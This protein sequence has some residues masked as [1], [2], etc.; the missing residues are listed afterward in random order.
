[1]YN[2]RVLAIEEP[3][4]PNRKQVE[5]FRK[6]LRTGGGSN[7]G[8]AATKRKWYDF[9]KKVYG[10]DYQ[11]EPFFVPESVLGRTLLQGQLR[12][13]FHRLV[14]PCRFWVL[15]NPVRSMEL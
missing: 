13:L 2:D 14:L 9:A 8:M 1:M 4:L 6:L 11:G 3:T 12:T 5:D 10:T 7:G 15:Y